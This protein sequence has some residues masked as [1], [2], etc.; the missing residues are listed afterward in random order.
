MEYQQYLPSDA[1]SPF[2]KCYW[3][4]TNDAQAA[5]RERIFPDGCMELIFHTG[6]LF[7]KYEADGQSYV[8]PRSFIHG[9]ITKCIEVEPTGKTVIFSVRFHPDGLRAFVNFDIAALTNTERPI[10]E[11]WGEEGAQLERSMRLAQSDQEKI[12]LLEAFL[13]QHVTGEQTD[14]DTRYCVGQMTATNGNVSLEQLAEKRGISKRQ[15]ERKFRTATGLPS[16][17]LARILRFQHTLQLIENGAFTN[18][19]HIAYDGGFYDQAHFIKDFRHFTGLNPKKYF[20]ENL[21]MAKY[22]IFD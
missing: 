1:L 4:L 7:R 22:F 17:M 20:S 18:F 6:D 14:A 3:T 13:M 12:S 11:V 21:E 10:A 9:Q 5:V 16:K 19:T 2:V 15:L 8:Q